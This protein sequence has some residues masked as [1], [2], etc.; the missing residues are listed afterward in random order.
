MKKIITLLA[1]ITILGIN[2]YAQQIPLHSQ[3]MMDLS[4]LNPAVAGS[5]SFS[6]I[7][8]SYRQQWVGFEGAPTTQYLSGHTYVGNHVGLGVSFFNELTTPSRRTGVQISFAY[9]LPISKDFSKKLSFGLSPVFFQH[10]IDISELTTEQLND[11]AVTNSINNQLC[12]DLNFGVMYSNSNEYYVG[13]SIFNLLEIRRDLFQIMD[14]IN[15]PIQRAFYLVGG[16]TYVINDNFSVEPSA[17]IQYQIH[18]PIQFDVNLRGMYKNIIGL[19]VSYRYT[20]AF[21]YMLFVNIKNF[22]LGYSY[23]MT[24]SD[25]RLYSSG[26]HEFHLTYRI[27]GK[28]AT[29]NPKFPIFY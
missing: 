6:P 11:P 24:N 22:R 21:V 13:L 19:G 8:A 20:D 15:N 17:L 5:Y 7:S 29:V 3:Y 16:Y 26:S 1:V 9:H 10:Y 2:G 23:D 14:K 4:I 25:I 27:W 18:A 12:P 28:G